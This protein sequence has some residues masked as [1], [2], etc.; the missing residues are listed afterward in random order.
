LLTIASKGNHDVNVMGC[1]SFS[2]F[3]LPYLCDIHEPLNIPSILASAV[4]KGIEITK[5]LI[6]LT[7][8][9]GNLTKDI[10]VCI[11]VLPALSLSPR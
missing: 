8:I 5:S 10:T 1:G 7:K 11:S 2:F 6:K 4:K 9:E 3:L